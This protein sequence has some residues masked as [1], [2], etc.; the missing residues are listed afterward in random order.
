MVDFDARPATDRADYRFSFETA[1]IV[2]LK[3][4]TV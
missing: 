4:S 2:F 1:V 3:A